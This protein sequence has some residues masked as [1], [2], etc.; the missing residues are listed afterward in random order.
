M[1]RKSTNL[2]KIYFSSPSFKKPLTYFNRLKLVQFAVFVLFP[3]ILWS[4]FTLPGYKLR[5]VVIDA[6]H[7]GKDAGCH[8]QKYYEKDVALKVA[9]KLGKYIEDNYKGIKVVYTRKTDVFIELNE[10]ARIAK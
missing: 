4:S 9:L 10:R 3:L 6:G 8:G 7:G 5:T 1:I 2:I